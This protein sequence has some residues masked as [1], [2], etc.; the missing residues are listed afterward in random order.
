MAQN[1]EEK[2][3]KKVTDNDAVDNN[4]TAAVTAFNERWMPWPRF[5]IGVEVMDV[6]QLRLLFVVLCHISFLH[7]FQGFIHVFEGLPAR[8][9]LLWHNLSIA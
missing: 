8:R 9:F 3:P 7:E 2:A 1:D 6:G 4:V 5:D